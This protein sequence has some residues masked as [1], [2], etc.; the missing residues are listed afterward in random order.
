MHYAVM[1]ASSRYTV[2]LV[3]NEIKVYLIISLKR[4]AWWQNY[5]RHGGGYIRGRHTK[6]RNCKLNI[7]QHRVVPKTDAF[8]AC[9]VVLKCF[10]NSK[11]VTKETRFHTSFSCNSSRG[12]ETR[13]WMSVL[14][15][16]DECDRLINNISDVSNR[17]WW[18]WKWM[19][20]ITLSRVFFHR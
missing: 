20:I 5:L 3:Q 1:C 12:R 11:T 2:I 17:R 6:S 8:F 15:H 18:T 4:I 19:R 9:A 10:Q 13:F 14:Y 16:W 7:Q